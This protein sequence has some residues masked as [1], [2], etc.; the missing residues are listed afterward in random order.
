MKYVSYKEVKKYL[1]SKG[2]QI[3]TPSNKYKDTAHKLEIICPNNCKFK[4]TFSNLKNNIDNGGPA[5]FLHK[6]E[7]NRLPFKDIEKI[8]KN[9]KYEKVKGLDLVE[10]SCNN[11]LS[12]K[13]VSD[14]SCCL[15]TE[16]SQCYKCLRSKWKKLELENIRSSESHSCITLSEKDLNELFYKHKNNKCKVKELIKLYGLANATFYKNLHLAYD[17]N[18][19]NFEA[20]TNI[21]QKAS[22][23]TREKLRKRKF[24]DEHRKNISKG[25]K[26]IPMSEK[27]KAKR[28]RT[29]EKKGYDYLRTPE[30]RKKI[31]Q[32]LKGKNKSKEHIIKMKAYMK[33][34]PYSN[35][36]TG[37]YK[38]KKAGKV[39]YR[40]SL[41]LKTYI[42]LDYLENVKSFI[43][44]PFVIDY[45]F[46]GKRK[47]RPDLKIKYND[48][49]AIAEIKP[50]NELYYDINIFKFAG[51]TRFCNKKSWYFEIFTEKYLNKFFEESED[52][53]KKLDYYLR[54][55]L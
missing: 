25:K 38:S 5:C 29:M 30:H 23:E 42:I 16:E 9:R 11:C 33:G 50:Y 41:E 10:K 2:F 15:F 39:Y 1:E 51:A 14:I 36:K 20:N 35:Y 43:A 22:E 26:G 45:I 40:S 32:A 37:F 21:G 8:F 31:S 12:N 47:Y 54:E 17:L 48:K 49:I 27:A 46:N 44:E 4:I 3:L 6:L 34:R 24:T 13:P 19:C 28:K 7:E 52:L 53:S 18:D 55:N